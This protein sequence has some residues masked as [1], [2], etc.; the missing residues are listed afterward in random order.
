MWFTENFLKHK[1]SGKTILLVDDHGSHCTIIVAF[2]NFANTTKN[3]LAVEANT[4]LEH[5]IFGKVSSF[6]KEIKTVFFFVL[7][8]VDSVESGTKKIQYG[9]PGLVSLLLLL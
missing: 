8:C 7:H 3:P 9:D 5:L 2:C 1:A 6:K 4:I